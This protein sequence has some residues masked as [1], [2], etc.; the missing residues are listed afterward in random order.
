MVRQALNNLVVSFYSKGAGINREKLLQHHRI[1]RCG[2]RDLLQA[3]LTLGVHLFVIGYEEPTLRRKFGAEYEE[4]CRH[5]RRWWPRLR[6]W[7]PASVN[8]A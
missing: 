2:P 8:V 6:S 3:D 7:T 4:Y 1:H 5:V